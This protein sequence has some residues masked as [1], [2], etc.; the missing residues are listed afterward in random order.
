M[1]IIKATGGKTGEKAAKP[2]KLI[3]EA[4]DRGLDITCDVYPYIASSTFL[5]ALL[6]PWVQEGGI[7]KLL[8][9][10]HSKEHR[11]RI[12]EDFIQG[13]PGWPNL[14]EE[15]RGGMGF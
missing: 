7:E 13:I 8:E 3:D 4:R 15:A 5:W 10:L 14:V 12:K 11:Q 1:P 2:C 6:P 9:R